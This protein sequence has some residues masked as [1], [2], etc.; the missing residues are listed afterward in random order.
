VFSVIVKRL[1]L[2]ANRTTYI[3]EHFSFF[4]LLQNVSVETYFDNFFFQESK[5]ENHTGY[6]THPFLAPLINKM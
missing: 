1:N 2:K 3:P 6:T 5:T 4:V